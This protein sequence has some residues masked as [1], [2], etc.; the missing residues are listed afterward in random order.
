MVGLSETYVKLI[1]IK[2]IKGRD[3]IG[4]LVIGATEFLQS[5]LFFSLKKNKVT[6]N[7]HLKSCSPKVETYTS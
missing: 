5:G 3:E 7:P 6:C 2:F 4:R 1:C